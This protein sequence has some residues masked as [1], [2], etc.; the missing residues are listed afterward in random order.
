MAQSLAKLAAAEQ[1]GGLPLPLLPFLQVTRLQS[2]V[3]KPEEYGHD[4]S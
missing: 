2:S 4:I 3:A 1:G